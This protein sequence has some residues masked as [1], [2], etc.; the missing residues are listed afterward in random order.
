MH[1]SET[2][3]RIGLYLFD[4]LN[5]T[6]KA[7]KDLQARQRNLEE[8]RF[9]LKI[10]PSCHGSGTECTGRTEDTDMPIYQPCRGCGGKGHGRD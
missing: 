2:S 8:I 10:C 9:I 4:E 5:R 7:I 6:E 1:A 3:Q